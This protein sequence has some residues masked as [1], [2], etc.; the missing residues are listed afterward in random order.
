[1]QNTEHFLVTALIAGLR[2]SNR[3]HLLEDRMDKS[4]LPIVSFIHD[5]ISSQIIVSHCSD[6]DIVCR[7]G[8]FLSPRIVQRELERVRATAQ[9][10]DNTNTNTMDKDSATAQSRDNTNTNTMDKDDIQPNRDSH[11]VVRLSLLHYNTVSEVNHC[12]QVLQ[13]IPGW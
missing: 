5:M 1:M 6:H 12:L 4:R 2:Q 7:Y 10:R 9:S 13:L 8:C 3:V 11:A